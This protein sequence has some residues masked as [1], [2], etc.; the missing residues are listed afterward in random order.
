[1]KATSLLMLAGACLAFSAH[2]DVLELKN[3]KTLNGKYVGGST[4]SIRFETAEGVQ[5]IET[6]QAL[7]LTF[8]G[9]ATTATG[10]PSSETAGA[11]ITNLTPTG[12]TSTPAKPATVPAGTVLL[13]RM[14]DPVSS[15][16]PQGKK[17]AATLDADVVV[18][19]T[20]VAKAGSKVYGRV[21]GSQQAGRAAGK[22]SLA[23]RLT[24][25]AVNGKTHPIV[26][27]D[28]ADATEHGEFRKTA[29]GAAVG[30]G[31]GAAFDDAGKGA[32][33]GAGASAVKKGDTIAVPTGAL[34]EF[35]LTQ[36]LNIGP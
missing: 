29:R 17:F 27:S 9:S 7:A 12:P 10:T 32:A 20:P 22:T 4:G 18:S 11:G 25:L 16:D 13:V 34:L 2:S 1:M 26:T 23:L 15:S 14:Q 8:T 21:E 24:E 6:G 33:I 5:V 35:R 30:A 36:P 28:Y 31:V 19:N 3:G